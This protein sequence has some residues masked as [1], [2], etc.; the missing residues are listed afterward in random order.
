MNARRVWFPLLCMTMQMVALALPGTAHAND[1]YGA[2][3]YINYEGEL[4]PYQ[5]EAEA[6]AAL[7]NYMTAGCP[8]CTIYVRHY[9]THA[10]DSELA[11]EVTT[12]PTTTGWGVWATELPSDPIK[13]AGSC[14][15]FNGGNG[16]NTTH[17]CPGGITVHDPINASTGNKFIQET[18]FVSAS[19]LNFRRFYN[20]QSIVPSGS[21]GTRWRHSFDRFLEI[22]LSNTGQASAINTILLDR[23]DGRREQF[24]LSNG[25]WNAEADNPDTL[26]EQDDASGHAIGYTVFMA[27]PQQVEKYSATGFL[28]SITDLSGTATTFTYSTVIT[29]ST[30]AP[31][32]NLL[33]TVTDPSG[34]VLNFTYDSSARLH[35]VTLPDAGVLTYAYD[36]NNNLASVT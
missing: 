2:P 14:S 1:Y 34:R 6:V 7:S 4:G 13:T 35:S 10:L 9:D 17:T 29:P 16:D 33:L 3:Y 20:S 21:L 28:Q 27:G 23:P 18:D 36:S 24:Q 25:V 15:P 5:S 26:T 12:D 8:T 22:N 32:P 19:A 31:K 30:V 11:A